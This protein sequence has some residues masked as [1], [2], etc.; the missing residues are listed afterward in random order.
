MPFKRG[1]S[2]NPNGRPKG[3]LNKTT[4]ELRSLISDFLNSNFDQVT[5]DFDLL[6]PKDRLKYY[7]ELLNFGLPRLQTSTIESN[8]ESL[9]DSQ[10]DQIINGIIKNSQ[11]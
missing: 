7:C 4:C 3:S 10:L 9:P 6:Q 1:E 11:N 2:G 8:Y 5:K